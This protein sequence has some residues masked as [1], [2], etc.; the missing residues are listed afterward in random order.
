MT[1][2]Q[3]KNKKSKPRETKNCRWISSGFENYLADLTNND[4]AGSP[5]KPI[6]FLIIGSGYGAAIAAR[7]LARQFAQTDS[8]EDPTQGDCREIVVFERGEEYLPG[9]FPDNFSELPTHLRIS[10]TPDGKPIGTSSGLF[11]LRTSKHINCLVANGLGGGSLIN[12][13]V[14]RR[15]PAHAFNEHWPDNITAQS[16]EP[17]FDQVEVLLGSH[18]RDKVNQKNIPI[19]VDLQSELEDHS[20]TRILDQQVKHINAN[21]E[22]STDRFNFETAAIT[23]AQKSGANQ[24]GVYLDK[25]INCADCATGCNH[26]AKNSLDANL[27][28]EAHSMGATIVTGVTALKIAKVEQPTD[29]NLWVAQCRYT[30]DK[31]FKREPGSHADQP[32]I[33]HVYAKNILIC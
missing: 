33:N 10:P 22:D 27:L 16:L 12:A 29:G 31:L 6:D 1:S 32:G 2:S 5:D 26:N 8:S 3:D 19:S 28:Y 7:Q 4:I 24:S 11:D 15:P 21:S 17:Y 20:K 30:N 14:M 25:C 18:Y 13:G 23:V 9:S